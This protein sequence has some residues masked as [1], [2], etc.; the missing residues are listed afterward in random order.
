M[1][2]DEI[3]EAAERIAQAGIGT[4]VLQSGEDP[5]FSAGHL[6][7]LVGRIR[8][9][10]G[11]AITL[12]VGERPGKEYRAFRAAGA[13]RYLL[14][15]ET[16]SA[17]LYARIRPES[18]YGSR[19]HCL[20]DLKALGYEVGTGNI[21]GLP[22][23]TPEHLA[24]DLLLMRDLDADMLGIGPFIPHPAT[25]LALSDPGETAMT[26]KVLALARLLTRNT[27]IPATTALD[28][29]DPGARVMALR[30]GANV[31]MPDFTPMTYRRLYDIYPGRNRTLDLDVFMKRLGDEIS[32]LGR[33]I[34]TGSG[35]RK[36]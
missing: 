21:V 12:S 25:P 23:Q 18:V 8:E 29:L 14:K 20:A 27:N 33:R 24:D 15:Y 2:D 5:F 7:N 6:C 19:L 1:R 17:E 31:V 32:S 16:T 9:S 35:R 34:G 30:T 36:K 28:T 13:D 11:L 26:L 4:A 10:T 3:V 22:G